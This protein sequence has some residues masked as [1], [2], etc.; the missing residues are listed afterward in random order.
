MSGY[1]HILCG[2]EV[3]VV[4][5]RAGNS[6]DAARRAQPQADML[7]MDVHV[8]GT[9]V[10]LRHAKVLRP[11]N[12]LWE[13]WYL[14]PKD[15]HGTAIE[16]VLS[17]LAPH[18]PLMVD[19]KCFT[20]RSARRV[21]EALRDGQPIIVSSRRWWTL[22]MFRDRPATRL[23]RSC[24]SPTQLYL[25]RRL[26][27]LGGNVGV[28]VHERLL[29]GSLVRSLRAETDLVFTWGATTSERCRE[30]VEFGVTGLILD[31]LGLIDIL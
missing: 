23:L 1:A 10:E 6:V 29:T 15:A 22:D 20:R 19:L 17:A 21:R 24:G 11:S 9:R 25:A 30:L 4:A 12:R 5:H 3:E 13:P 31:D 26:P 8:L 14:L 28:S 27:G 16:A 18:T 2:R 7:E